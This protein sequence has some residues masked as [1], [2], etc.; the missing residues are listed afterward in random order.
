MNQ[1]AV[2]IMIDENE[3][4]MEGIHSLSIAKAA[5]V[6]EWNKNEKMEPSPKCLGGSKE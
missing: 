6:K 4:E 2:R 1:I 3:V 5:T